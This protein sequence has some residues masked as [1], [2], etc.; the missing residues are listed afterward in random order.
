[1]KRLIFGSIALILCLMFTIRAGAEDPA[2][3][4]ERMEQAA[5]SAL[6]AEQEANDPTL[7]RRLAMQTFAYKLVACDLEEETP[8]GT[9]SKVMQLCALMRA[10]LKK[11]FSEDEQL[12]IESMMN[13]LRMS[14]LN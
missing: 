10:T 11:D 13:R 5:D 2:H 6:K 1:M 8:L 9:D 3:A 12:D 14:T 7:K 4:A